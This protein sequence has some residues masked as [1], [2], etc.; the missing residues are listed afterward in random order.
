VEISGSFNLRQIFLTAL[1]AILA[2]SACQQTAKSPVT[3][4]TVSLP[5]VSGRPGAAYFTLHGGAKDTR[6]MEVR[7]PDAIRVEL[8]ESMKKDGM[9]SMAPIEGGVAVPAGGT[10]IFSPGGKHAMLFDMK[11]SL[12]AGDKVKLAFSFADGSTIDV[13]AEARA[14]GDAGGGHAH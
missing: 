9:M 3:D 4:A 2:L 13:D 1:S 14:P 11:P 6:L 12:K 10:V 5:A 7:T 8:H